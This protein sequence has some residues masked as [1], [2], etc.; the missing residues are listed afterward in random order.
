M[1]DCFLFLDNF[2]FFSIKYICDTIIYPIYKYVLSSWNIVITLFEYISNITITLSKHI[3]NI[4][5][6]LFEYIR[7]II[8]TLY[9][10]LQNTITYPICKYVSVLV[11]HI[12][13]NYGKLMLNHVELMLNYILQYVELKVNYILQNYLLI[14]IYSTLTNTYQYILMYVSFCNNYILKQFYTLCNHIN[15]IT[16]D[17]FNMTNNT[18]V[19]IYNSTYNIIMKF[20]KA[21]QN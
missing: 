6:V 17:I 12:W 2:I 1:V 14:P 8:I 19:N 20:N 11:K 21:K 9:Q 16:D 10:Y 13:N 7:Y 18:I 4:T 5:V 3:W 15:R